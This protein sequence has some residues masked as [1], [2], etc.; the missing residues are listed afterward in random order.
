MLVIVIT[1]FDQ[2]GQDEREEAK[3]DIKKLLLEEKINK[4]IFCS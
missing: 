2:C 1:K 4:V 3:N